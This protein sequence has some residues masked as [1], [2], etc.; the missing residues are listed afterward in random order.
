MQTLADQP[1]E[2]G[3]EGA[4]RPP[5]SAGGRAARHLIPWDGL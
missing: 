1:H 2:L 5:H 3:C 4:Q